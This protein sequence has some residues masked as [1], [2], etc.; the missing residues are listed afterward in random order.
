MMSVKGT[1]VLIATL[2]LTWMTIA[3]CAVA[4]DLWPWI[5]ANTLYAV[6][7]GVVL[8]SPAEGRKPEPSPVKVKADP[9]ANAK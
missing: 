5:V 6:V 9:N 3:V 2:M 4:P 1:T 8:A 7:V